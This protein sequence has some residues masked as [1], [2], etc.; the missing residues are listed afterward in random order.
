M[1][2]RMGRKMR[3][4]EQ[5]F[6]AYMLLEFRGEKEKIYK[7]V[8]NGCVSRGLWMGMV[9]CCSG[10][11]RCYKRKL[12]EGWKCASEQPNLYIFSMGAPSTPPSPFPQ[13]LHLPSP[14]WW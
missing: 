7:L 1:K 13:T 14:S 4:K 8:R 6:N 11:V 5:F 12:D 9:C 2:R 10:N 3:G